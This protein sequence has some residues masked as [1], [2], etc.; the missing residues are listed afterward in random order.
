MSA[1]PTAQL[2]AFAQSVYLM[3]KNRYYDDLTTTDGQV[4]LLQVVDWINM[5]IDELEFEVNSDGDPIDWIWVRQNVQIGTAVTGRNF[6]AWDSD[7]YNNLCSGTDRYVRILDP[8]GSGN[9]VANFLVISA[10]ELNNGPD[11]GNIDACALLNGNIVFSRSF[12]AAENNGKIWADVTIYIPRVTTSTNATTGAIIATNVDAFST[13]RPLTLL[14]L[15]TVKNAIL[16]D[17][18]KGGL[19]PSYVQ[20]YN[21]LLGNAINRSLASSLSPTAN[22]DDF[23]NIRGVGF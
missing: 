16:P 10:D 11:S 3:L 4:Y 13:V 5:Y 6:I 18:V 20:K 12:T 15:G 1:S 8:A 23:G 22:Y 9:A 14:K 21:D 2:Q 19:Q 7:D 17:I